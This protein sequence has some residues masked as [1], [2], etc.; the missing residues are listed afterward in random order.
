[1]SHP[2]HGLPTVSDA[3]VTLANDPRVVSTVVGGTIGGGFAARLD[4]INSI[5]GTASLCVGF[6]TTTVICAVQIVKLV[7]YWRDTTR[8]EPK[9]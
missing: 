8:I 6:I 1:M 4:M 5:I 9:E 3:V 2:M 7:R